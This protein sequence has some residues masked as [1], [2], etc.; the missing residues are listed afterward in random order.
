MPL[1]PSSA[2]LRIF[3]LLGGR[4]RLVVL[5]AVDAAER[6]ASIHTRTELTAA[7]RDGDSWLLDLFDTVGKTVGLGVL[8]AG[9]L[10]PGDVL[11]L[12]GSLGAGK[13]VLTRGIAV[14]LG[15][16]GMV[17]S[18]TFILLIEHPARAGGIALYHFDA[19]R[20][21]GGGE[22]CA[23]GL[24]EYFDG[25]GICVIEWG[26][27]IAEMLPRRTLFI[28]LGSGFTARSGPAG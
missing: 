14:G 25:D 5:N 24:D 21:S 20:L 9:Q 10:R 22:F 3:R 4:P 1:N 23:S 8:L 17:T 26:S 18:P 19:Y 27:Q 7:R 28:S 12:N 13:T 11:S 2:G 15:C 16:R 6:G